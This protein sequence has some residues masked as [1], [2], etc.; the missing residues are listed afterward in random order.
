V[1]GCSYTT[2]PGRS[3][4]SASGGGLY[5]GASAQAVR[6]NIHFA[7]NLNDARNWLVAQFEK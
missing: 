3:S 6:R 1:L 5:F 7:G 4:P 2:R